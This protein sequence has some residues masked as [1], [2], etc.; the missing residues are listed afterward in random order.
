MIHIEDYRD[1]T[2]RRAIGS[3]WEEPKKDFLDKLLYFVMFISGLVAT[4]SLVTLILVV[5]KL[6]SN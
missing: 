5:M 3:S 4:S 6:I 1:E 2:V